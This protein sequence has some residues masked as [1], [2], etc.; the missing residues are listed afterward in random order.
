MGFA[1]VLTTASLV[2]A[3]E[4]RSRSE[5][6]LQTTGKLRRQVSQQSLVNFQNR[7]KTRDIPSPKE[8]DNPSPRIRSLSP[9]GVREEVYLP[10]RSIPPEVVHWDQW[11]AEQLRNKLFAKSKI[12]QAH[13][14][15]WCDWLCERWWCIALMIGASFRRFCLLMSC[16]FS[17]KSG[18]QMDR[19]FPNDLDYD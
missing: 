8:H 13:E 15:S 12:Q 6:A 11:D 18:T 1:L 5:G 19:E 16:G 14:K 7:A 3:M 17:G 10:D 2:S 4:M 9:K